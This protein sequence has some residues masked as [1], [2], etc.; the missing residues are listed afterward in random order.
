MNEQKFTNIL[1]GFINNSLVLFYYPL[2]LR[3]VYFIDQIM[4]FR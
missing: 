4:N 1:A 2:K 3:V